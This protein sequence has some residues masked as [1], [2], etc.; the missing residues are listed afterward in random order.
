MVRRILNRV[1]AGPGALLLLIAIALYAL[2][3]RGPIVAIAPVIDD[4]RDSLHI[5]GSTAGL[6]TSLPV[7]CFA[8]ASPFASVLLARAG[9][10]RAISLSLLGILVG[11]LIRASGGFAAALVGTLIIGVA[12]TVGNVAVPVLI[13][14]DFAHD[15]GLVTAMYASALNIGA[16]VTSVLT[17]PLADVIGWRA[18]LIAWGALALVAVVTWT[19]AASR[20]R[21]TSAPAPSAKPTARADA[22]SPPAALW[23][24]PF[25]WG[26]TL[27][28]GSQAFGYY[29]VTAWLPTLLHDEIGLGRSA[30]GASASIF[31][32]MAVVGAFGVPALLTRGLSSSTVLLIVC[33]L[34][35]V[36]PVGLLVAPAAWPLWCALGG[37]AQG[38]GFTAIFTVVVHRAIDQRDGRRISATVQAGGYTLA[39]TGPFAVG[40][41]HDASGG[42]T[43]PLL[44]VCVALAVMAVAGAAACRRPREALAQR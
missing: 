42:W 27:A 14:R 17:A 28:F 9:I 16:M 40:A 35:F 6:L 32:V 18:A 1:A 33:S 24:R 8:V 38:G 7:A 22:Q 11:T 4:V 5:G 30:A 31:Q 41:L 43:A 3:M 21:A 19:R 10:E 34:W 36:L 29:G 25:V 20:R 12:I 37:T 39:A 44:A 2:N 15:A 26:L 23:R 13:G